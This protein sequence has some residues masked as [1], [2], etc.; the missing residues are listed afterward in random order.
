MIIDDLSIEVG[1]LPLV[2]IAWIW[3]VSQVVFAVRR[4]GAWR[5]A[6]AYW[7]VSKAAFFTVAG[8]IWWANTFPDLWFRAVLY[9]LIAAKTVAFV[10]WLGQ[11]RPPELPNKE[12]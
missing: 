2:G 10:I 11:P 7:L 8:Y 1:Y 5:W 6:M 9:N 4:G 3:A 12:V